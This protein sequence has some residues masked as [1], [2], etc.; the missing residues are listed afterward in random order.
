MGCF[1]KL[2]KINLFF[3]DYTYLCWFQKQRDLNS[4]L[5]LIKEITRLSYILLTQIINMRRH[6]LKHV[7]CSL[8]CL[9]F[10]FPF[11]S[12]WMGRLSS[13]SYTSLCFWVMLSLQ[14]G[15]SSSNSVGPLNCLSDFMFI[16]FPSICCRTQKLT[17]IKCIFWNYY[18]RLNNRTV[19]KVY[20]FS[21]SFWMWLHL[22][23]MFLF[24]PLIL[25]L[26]HM[27]EM[28]IRLAWD[29]KSLIKARKL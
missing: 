13:S 28:Q 20:P 5:Q 15:C 23:V 6:R 17:L 2:E 18:V 4:S 21:G 26:K 8:L 29:R 12:R 22:T 7:T 3:S 24:E 14:R 25:S 11:G 27:K 1:R 16:T 19:K 9:P 10:K